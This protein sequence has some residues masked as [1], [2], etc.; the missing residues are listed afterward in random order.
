ML[1]KLPEIAIASNFFTFSFDT[2]AE[3][4]TEF[5][6]YSLTIDESIDVIDLVQLAIFIRGFHKAFKFS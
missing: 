3:K 6:P 4:S 2:L 5:S 1:K